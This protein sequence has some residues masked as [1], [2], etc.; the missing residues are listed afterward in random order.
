MD[1]SIN[2]GQVLPVLYLD[3]P[4]PYHA[5]QFLLDLDW[6]LKISRTS[7]IYIRNI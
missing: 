7:G 6:M 2:I 5:A 3:L 1:D 4:T